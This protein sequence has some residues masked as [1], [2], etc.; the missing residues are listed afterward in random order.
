MS[1]ADHLLRMHLTRLMAW[2]RTPIWQRCL[3]LLA[4][5]IDIPSTISLGQCSQGNKPNRMP[6][7]SIEQCNSQTRFEHPLLQR[8]FF[9]AKPLFISGSNGKVDLGVKLL[10][11]AICVGNLQKILCKT[12]MLSNV[13]LKTGCHNDKPNECSRWFTLVVLAYARAW[14]WRLT[15]SQ[16]LHP[17][18]RLSGLRDAWLRNIYGFSKWG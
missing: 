10:V 9:K 12:K 3:E 15:D 18:G 5:V 7:C 17:F 8:V 13:C 11:D 4:S 1:R 6:S 14:L 16:S 2:N